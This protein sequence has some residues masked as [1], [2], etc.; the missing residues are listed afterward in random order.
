MELINESKEKYLKALVMGSPGVG[1]S[2]LGAT[3]PN[4]LILLSE[5]HGAASIMQSAERLGV[6]R[7]TT[8]FMRSLTDYRNVIS[9]LRGDQSKPFTIQYQGKTLVEGA[10]PQTVVLDSLTDACRLIEDEIRASGKDTETMSQAQYGTLKVRCERMISAFRDVPMHV[11]FLCL[12]DDKGEDLDRV[13]KPQ[14]PGRNLA[15]FA[16]ACVNVV[17]VADRAVTQTKGSDAVVDYRAYTVRPGPYM[18]KPMRPLRDIEEMNF[19][20]WVARVFSK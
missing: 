20:K 11:L 6:G 13:I 19:S 5:R 9:A 1:K 7:P 16:M 14:L 15:S 3:A 4:P 17:A 10:W 18:L 8:L 2:S 12:M